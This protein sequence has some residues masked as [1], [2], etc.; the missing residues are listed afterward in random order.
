MHPFSHSCAYHPPSLTGL[1]NGVPHSLVSFI[2]SHVVGNLVLSLYATKMSEEL[3][4]KKIEENKDEYINFFQEIVQT[5]SYNPPGN[6]K[7]V[8]NKI[9]FITLSFL[10]E[11]LRLSLTGQPFFLYS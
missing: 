7:N 5:D 4:L 10:V 6:E 3:I 1:D 8:A 9:G 2:L 11:Y